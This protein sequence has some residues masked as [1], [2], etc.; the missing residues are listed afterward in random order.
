VERLAARLLG[1]DDSGIRVPPAQGTY[2]RGHESSIVF[3]SGV[4][5][6]FAR[7]NF[8]QRG[9]DCAERSW[10]G[11]A[12]HLA[13]LRAWVLIGGCEL[14]ASVVP[15]QVLQRTVKKHS[16]TKRLGATEKEAFEICTG[17]R[18]GV[19]SGRCG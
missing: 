16:V 15:R 18:V 11:K 10:A 1:C 2:R 3:D 8:A 7:A 12:K 13:A 19:C 4:L 17:V 6:H 5:K 14:R 9:E